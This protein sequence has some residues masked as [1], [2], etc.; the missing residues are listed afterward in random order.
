MASYAASVSP[1]GISDMAG[2][3]WEMA[4]SVLSPAELVLRGGS[5]YHGSIAAAV[6]NREPIETTTRSPVMGFRICGDAPPGM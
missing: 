6:T 2:N 5:Y 1:F 3:V 4:T